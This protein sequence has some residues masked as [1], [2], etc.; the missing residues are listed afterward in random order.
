MYILPEKIDTTCW[1]TILPAAKGQSGE[2]VNILNALILPVSKH[3]LLTQLVIIV[4]VIENIY[5]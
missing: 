3:R 4:V 1:F 5:R 2:R